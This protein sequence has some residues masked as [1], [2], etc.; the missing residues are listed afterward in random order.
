MKVRFFD[1]RIKDKKLKRMLLDSV[2]NVLSHGQLL[3]GPEVKKF[4]DQIAIRT[5]SKYAVAVGSGSS[6]LYLA[7]KSIGIKKGDEVITSPLTWIITLNAI[8]ECGAIPVCVD[9]DD[10]FNIDPRKIKKAVTKKTK[11][12]VPVHFTGLMCKMDEIKK[13]AKK[14]NLKIIEDAAQAFDAK[15]KGK[16]VG[17]LSDATTFSF[18]V[19]KSLGGFGEAGAVTTN[20]KKIYEMV[21]MLRYTGTKSDPKK[22][23]TNECYHVA[24]NHKI[25]TLQAAMLLVILKN[26]KKKMRRRLEIAKLYNKE[27]NDYVTCPVIESKDCVHGLYTYAIQTNNRNK[28]MKYLNDKGIQNKIYHI[29]LASDAPVFKKYRRFETPN[30]RKVLSRFLSIPAHEK[31]TFS[32][33]KYVINNIKN[34]FNKK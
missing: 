19:M 30:A 31:I 4:E 20:N 11:A 13:I 22:I 6:A 10:D 7:L 14:Y 18:N 27:L 12:I 28:L 16:K 1:L 15:H 3:L 29:P 8:A 23:I 17:T 24:L 26:F 21:K 34:F 25:D 32:E 9:I 33:Q 5:G 2:N